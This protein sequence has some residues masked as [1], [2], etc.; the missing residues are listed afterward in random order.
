MTVTIEQDRS[1]ARDEAMAIAEHRV[2]RKLDRG[3]TP[4]RIDRGD[5]EIDRVILVGFN[6][7]V[8]VLVEGSAGD[9]SDGHR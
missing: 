7:G 5:A 3:Q 8:H 4:H 9:L 1:A 6:D 2:R